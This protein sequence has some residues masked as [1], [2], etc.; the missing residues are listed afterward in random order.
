MSAKLAAAI[1]DVPDF[2]KPGILFKDI[3]PILNDPALFREA[4]DLF[5]ARHKKTRIEKVA[6][7]EARGFI[8]G[9]AIAHRLGVGFV[10][11]RKKGKLPYKT[12]DET[13]DLEYGSASI[14]VHTDAF[15]SGER[16]LIVDDLLAT[17]GTAAAAARLVKRAGGAV[18]E[19]D[20]LIEL[21]FLKGREKLAGETVFAPIVF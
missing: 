3:T 10:P 6:G 12:L 18:V 16:V 9:A 21:A 14:S 8:F 15:R 7:I 1:R 20:F 11:I 5:V 13:Y 19:I 17:G 4:I 2:P